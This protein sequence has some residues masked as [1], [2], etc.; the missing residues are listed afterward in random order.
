[1]FDLFLLITKY[2]N[3]LDR[4]GLFCCHRFGI[5]CSISFVVVESFVLFELDKNSSTL[6]NFLRYCFSTVMLKVV[7]WDESSIS[8]G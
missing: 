4:I 1:M 5:F 8:L 7:D 6:L 2:F 3:N